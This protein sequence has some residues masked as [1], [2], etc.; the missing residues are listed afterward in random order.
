MYKSYLQ[1]ISIGIA[2]LQLPL[3]AQESRASLGGTVTDPSGAVVTA[4]QLKLLNKD[5][6]ITFSAVSNETGQ[7]R[8][9][10]LNPGNYQLTAEMQGFNS[11]V[12]D[13][14]ELHGS[15]SAVVDISLRIGQSSETVT[16]TSKAPLL[17][18][19]KADRGLVIDNK[20]VE[21]L[22]LNI[23]NAIMLSA[24]SPGIVH[25]SGTQHLNPFSN[26]GR[27]VSASLR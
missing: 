1:L 26:N 25:T 18:A 16:I 20:Q 21:D 23:R 3:C 14:L 7:Y 11:F 5:T 24:L 8:F 12:R 6:G 17:E 4:A 2:L 22:P 13:N 27:W 9:L 10:F 19:D 15:Q